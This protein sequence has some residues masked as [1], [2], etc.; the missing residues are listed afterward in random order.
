MS[1]FDTALRRIMTIPREVLKQAFM[2]TRYDPTRAARYYD[3]TIPLS[4]ET[5]I[6]DQVIL[7]RVMKD[8]D[9]VSG[10]EIVIPLYGVEY[11]RVDPFNSIFRLSDR[12][13]GGRTITSCYEVT[14]GR[15]S[16]HSHGSHGTHAGYSTSTSS[17]L[18]AAKDV[19]RA[20]TGTSSISTS[21]VQIIGHNVILVND[22]SLVGTYGVLRCQVTNDPNL[23]NLRTQYHQ[24]FASLC[25]HAVRAYVYSSLVI[26]LDEGA[27]RGGQTIGRFRE[28]VDNFAD[29][30]TIYIE[31]LD[32]WQK[33]SILN[34]PVQS[35]R[36]NRLALGIRPKL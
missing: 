10:T 9:L 8:I 3:N 4:I 28:I 16:T 2:P 18:K 33:I 15:S 24:R 27:L 23:N 32:M 26:D 14:Y 13:T 12:D 35:R 17:L 7:G 21:H 11:E 20:S 29:A 36:A 34:D 25:L 31:E 22:V 30:D 6:K 5:L 19:L 1:A